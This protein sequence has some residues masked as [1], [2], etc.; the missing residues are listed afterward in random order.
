MQFS[1]YS[2]YTTPSVN[3]FLGFRVFKLKNYQL[4]S[5]ISSHDLDLSFSEF[6]LSRLFTKFEFQIWEIQIWISFTVWLQIKKVVSYKLPCWE[7]LHLRLFEKNQIFKWL[8]PSLLAGDI[9]HSPGRD[10]LCWRVTYVALQHDAFT[11][12]GCRA[13]PLCTT[14]L[15]G[16]NTLISYVPV[17]IVSGVVTWYFQFQFIYGLN[18]NSLYPFSFFNSY[19]I[20]VQTKTTIL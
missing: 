16:A 11:A 6:L 3:C 12:G 5:F 2:Y 8:C 4:Q 9:S 1:F 17:Q 10:H 19:T 20:T 7:F 15:A 18:W 13:M 14:V